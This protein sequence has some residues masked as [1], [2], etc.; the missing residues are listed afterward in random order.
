MRYLISALLLVGLAL[1]QDSA[2]EGR[3]IRITTE[4]GT[5][6]GNIRYGPIRF[7]HP[8]PDGITATVSNLTIRSGLA[9]LAVPAD[10]Q[11]DVLL[12]EA[13]GSREATFSNGV[14]V[15]RG[16]LSATGPGLVYS[17]ATGL[18][19]LEGPAAVTVLPEEEGGDP[20][21]ITAGSVEFD[22]DTD[23]SVSRGEVSLES[24]NQ[25]AAA[26]ELLYVEER[27]L[28]V[29]SSGDGQVRIVRLDDNG[30]ELVITADSVRVLTGEEKLFASGNVT[31]VD[32]SITSTGESVFFDD[33]TSRAEVLGSPARSVDSADGFEL[34]GDRLE[35]RTDLGVVSIIDASQPSEFDL[36]AFALE[37]GELD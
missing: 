13:E 31:V 34:Q 2:P 7:E 23:R 37:E 4:D 16:R 11:D 21:S 9:T 27:S 19:M 20:V 22:V 15:E 12:S 29:L 30:S 24:G 32:G 35:H 10:Q 3:I 6:S 1:A 17:E 8:D 26:E 36:T 33:S 28:G 25:T 18:G 5:T 14:S